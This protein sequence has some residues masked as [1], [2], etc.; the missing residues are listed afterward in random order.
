VNPGDW[1][2]SQSLRARVLVVRV[3]EAFGAAAAQVW[4]PGS[5]ALVLVPV[6]DL[7]DPPEES[8]AHSLIAA[9]AAARIVEA[10][11]TGTLVSPTQSIV[12]PL[13]HQLRAL[14][15]CASTSPIRMLLADEVGLG[16]TIEAGLV[17]T[18]LI[19]RGLARR[20]LVVAPTGLVPQWQG[21]LS[22]RFGEDFVA[23]S[24]AEVGALAGRREDNF[25]RAYD[26]LIVPL[27]AVKPM[28]GRRGWTDEQVER[29]N[30]ARS[31]NLAAAGWDIVIIDEAHRVAGFDEQ[32]A[33]H[34]LARLLAEA[35]PN[36]LLLSATPHAG[37]TDGFRR[38]LSLLDRRPFAGDAAITPA[39][40]QP[41]VVRT[42]KRVA[43]DAAGAPL[44]QPRTT[45]KVR[46]DWPAERPR[47][48][49]LYDEVTAYVQEG[50]DLGRREKNNSL[51]FLMLLMQ[52]IVSS[53]TRAIE[54]ALSR[55]LATLVEIEA[56]AAR[57]LDLRLDADF[58]EADAEDQ[59][60]RVLGAAVPGVARERTTVQR[61]LALAQ[62]ARA[63]GL[64]VKLERLY[65]LVVSLEQ[66]ENDPLAK[67]LVFTEF[68]PTQAMIADFLRSMGLNVA[69][70]NGS[71]PVEDRLLAQDEFA[72]PAQVLVSTEAGGEGLNLQVAHLVINYDLPWNP[73]RIEQRIGRVD[74]I[75]QTKPVRAFNLVLHGSVEDRVHD[76]LETKLARVLAEFGVDKLSDVLD[77]SAFESAFQTAYGDAVRGLDVDEIT[78]VLAAEVERAGAVLRDWRDLLGGEMPDPEE[79]RA[80]RD[81]PLPLWVERMTVAGVL[82]GG[83]SADRLAGA[84]RIH[85]PEGP[86]EEVAFRRDL[87]TG[88]RRLATLG[89]PRIA[90]VLA[91]ATNGEVAG[92]LPRAELRGMGAVQPGVW[93]L[94][95]VGAHL[96]PSHERR[97]MPLFLDRGGGVLAA[98]ARAIWER[99]MEPNV[100]VHLLA[101]GA[102]ERG[103]SLGDSRVEAERLAGGIYGSLRDALTERVQAERARYLEYVERR[104]RLI[105]RIGL[106]NVRRRRLAEL[107]AE[108]ERELARL[109]VLGVAP[110]LRCIAA[111]EVVS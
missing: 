24:S 89:D 51:V 20:V 33:R 93:T 102:T 45:S 77:S 67:I 31:T 56:R 53:S 111:F 9:A 50:Y 46:V 62:D 90:A 85:W 15:R 39:R 92:P 29:H 63:E 49:R 94:W 52:R 1:R 17:M 54:V 25:W 61:L 86:D 80:M 107:E 2:Y 64:D 87:A 43:I 11:A 91:E 103:G 58:W 79:A 75:G 60:E 21:E 73:M 47:Q 98:T 37:K 44:F 69:I 88:G 8:R 97:A 19:L 4:H 30:V 55:R 72:G 71:M 32:V 99:L 38:V 68:V 82:A 40:V 42:S 100:E 59:A 95:I 65:D 34:R 22:R 106:D 57:P 78:S 81:H 35:T 48:R 14:S 66:E 28:E 70:L 23:I 3:D 109:P 10:L 104:R 110:E 84:W 108:R 13:P 76:L 6:G 101:D 105:E 26:R 27:D 12:E 7:V 36:L 74:R 18:E 41:Y 16:K 96:G 5:P 83:G